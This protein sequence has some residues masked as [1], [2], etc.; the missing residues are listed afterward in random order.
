MND[1]FYTSSS[2]RYGYV[3]PQTEH[4]EEKSK[5]DFCLIPLSVLSSTS[6]DKSIKWIG[7]PGTRKEVRNVSPCK[8]PQSAG[9]GWD[10]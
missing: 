4:L 3:A 8:P 6:K 10:Y 2:T 1:S 9:T 5:P 7:P